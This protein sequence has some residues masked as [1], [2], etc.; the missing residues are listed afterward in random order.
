MS[1]Y[2]N[3]I[4]KTSS[5]D[6]AGRRKEQASVKKTEI[7]SL[8]KRAGRDKCKSKRKWY[9]LWQVCRFKVL[10]GKRQERKKEKR[11][12]KKTQKN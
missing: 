12:K 11:C 5:L 9:E 4:T 2:C 10:R 7:N 6:A 1:Q 3:M 8:E